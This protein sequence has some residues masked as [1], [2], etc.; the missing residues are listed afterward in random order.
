MPLL[1]TEN[2]EHLRVNPLF[3]E[4]TDTSIVKETGDAYLGF[5]E[6]IKPTTSTSTYMGFT[7]FSS[8]FEKKMGK[9]RLTLYFTIGCTGQDVNK[10]G[11]RAL[12]PLT[13][14]GGSNPSALVYITSAS[15][16]V[17]RS[18]ALSLAFTSSRQHS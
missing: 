13:P 15:L 18:G 1:S 3:L 17:A 4:N 7:P 11:V 10:A 8:L 9:K 12:S 2:F 16:G 5:M 6:F 14:F